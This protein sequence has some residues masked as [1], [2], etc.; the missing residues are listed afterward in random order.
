MDGRTDGWMEG[1]I[2]FF[3]SDLPAPVQVV[4]FPCGCELPGDPAWLPLPAAR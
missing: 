1:W 4:L 2:G 3:F